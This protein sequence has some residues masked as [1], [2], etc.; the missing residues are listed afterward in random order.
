MLRA[1]QQLTNNAKKTL[2]DDDFLIAGAGWPGWDRRGAG[3][4]V[5]L[6]ENTIV[7]EN[8]IISHFRKCFQVPYFRKACFWA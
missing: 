6:F 7:T 3:R 8:T 2:E 5:M 1:Q 4:F